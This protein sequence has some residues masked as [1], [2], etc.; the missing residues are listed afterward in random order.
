MAQKLRVLAAFPEALRLVPSIYLKRL[1]S[2]INSSSRESNTVF[3]SSRVP[4][5]VCA[6]TRMHPYL[7]I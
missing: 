5:H 7:Q 3:W 6:Y 2:A 4:V 1:T